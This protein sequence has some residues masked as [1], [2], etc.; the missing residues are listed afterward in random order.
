MLKVR[1][2]LSMRLMVNNAAN[3]KSDESSDAGV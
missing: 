2:I 3:S 1:G